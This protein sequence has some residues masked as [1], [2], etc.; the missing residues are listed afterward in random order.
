MTGVI[1][2]IILVFVTWIY[3]ALVNQW[4]QKHLYYLYDAKNKRIMNLLETI[5][6]LLKVVCVIGMAYSCIY[7]MF[8]WKG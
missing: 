7:L 8:V 4:Y 5:E 2:T 3:E 1:I 6:I